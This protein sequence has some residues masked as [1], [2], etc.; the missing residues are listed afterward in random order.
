MK[1]R[2]LVGFG[3]LGLLVALGSA[4]Q[5]VPVT[6][7]PGRAGGVAVV[8]E[9]CP[10]FSWTSVDWA[11]GYRVA[12]FDAQ[13]LGAVSYEQMASAGIEPVLSREI[14]GRGLSWTPSSEE[15]LR[16]GAMYVWYVEAKSPSGP[17]VWSA[18]SVFIVGAVAIGTG[19]E[20]R[21]TKVLREKEIREEVITDVLK[22]MKSGAM[23][24]VAGGVSSKPQSEV[25]AMGTEGTENTFYGQGAGANTTGIH[26]SFFGASAGYNN[27]L[28]PSLTR[29]VTQRSCNSQ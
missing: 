25:R 7:S 3:L 15:G 13:G 8:S 20:E 19:T 10:T 1:R 28:G 16:T 18:G 17:G 2:A 24:A 23:G 21:V 14:E 5:V 26:N 9:S 4:T 12:V 22:D 11:V 6:V 29:L 27:T